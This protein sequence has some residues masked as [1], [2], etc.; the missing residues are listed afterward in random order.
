LRTNLT[1]QLQGL[2]DS[3]GVSTSNSGESDEDVL[4]E[5]LTKELQESLNNSPSGKFGDE[6]KANPK[7]SH[8]YIKLLGEFDWLKDVE[9]QRETEDFVRYCWE[10]KDLKSENALTVHE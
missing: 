10:L 5:E 7:M 8:K 9:I 1:I 3:F 6:I 4:S 2:F